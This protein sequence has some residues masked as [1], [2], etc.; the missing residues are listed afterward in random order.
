MSIEKNDYIPFILI[1]CLAFIFGLFSLKQK[2]D[3]NN[4]KI[5]SK[6]AS[7]LGRILL[8]IGLFSELAINYLPESIHSIINFFILF[9]SIGLYSLVF[10]DKRFDKILLAIIIIQIALGS[11][12]NATLI[13]FIIFA[14]FFTMFYSLR[15]KTSKKI[16][17]TAFVLSISF[18][19]AYQAIKSEY[20]LLVWENAVGI[21]KKI[22]LITNSNLIKLLIIY[23]IYIFISYNFFLIQ[24]NK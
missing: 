18:L 23:L 14:L 12:L 4:L 10:S 19:I 9:K 2:I 22:E 6:L 11:I 7:K 1:V 15:Y 20:R 5:S 13:E 8:G 16:K 3:I 24:I 21:E 17:V